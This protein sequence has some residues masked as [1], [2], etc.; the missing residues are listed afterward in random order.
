MVARLVV[1]TVG[2]KVVELDVSKDA[3]MAAHLVALMAGRKA[4]GLAAKMVES[5]AL[6]RVVLRAASLVGMSAAL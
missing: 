4:D 3:S 2:E 6:M 5:R 1:A